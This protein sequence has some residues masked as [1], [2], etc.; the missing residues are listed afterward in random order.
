MAFGP[1]SDESAWHRS[2]TKQLCMRAWHSTRRGL[3]VGAAAA[4]LPTWLA[5]CAGVPPEQAVDFD[6][7]DERV[8][9]DRGP[10][11]HAANA[12]LWAIAT[13]LLLAALAQLERFD[14]AALTPRQRLQAGTLRWS[15][16]TRLGSQI[17]RAAC[18]SRRN[19]R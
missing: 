14:A 7:W 9:A 6:A 3:L 18:A 12:R 4:A 5:S 8:A 13:Q 10:P 17:S 19:R 15:L 1:A 2:R 16:Q 11:S